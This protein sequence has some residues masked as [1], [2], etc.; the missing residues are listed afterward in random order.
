M[1]TIKRNDVYMGRNLFQATEITEWLSIHGGLPFE[2]M[3][4]QKEVI[5]SIGNLER[6]GCF[7]DVGTGKTVMSVSI[8]K[9]KN[10]L[11]SSRTLIIVPPILRYQWA[12]SLKNFGETDITVYDG[13][14]KERKQKD[15]SAKW[16]IVGMEIFKKDFLILYEAFR[17]DN[18]T[19]IVDEAVSVKNSESE[20]H[21]SLNDFLDGNRHLVANRRSYAKKKSE[22]RKS[23][24]SAG[25][26]PREFEKAKKQED[27]KTKLDLLRKRLRG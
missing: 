13:P 15:L 2:L 19:V 25:M 1:S 6:S 16:V 20:N 3:P 21:R 11:Y 10:H 23:A 4:F 5:Q 12:R 22:E 14:P 9:W 17:E 26:T 18:V 7:A 8:A 27:V 24:K